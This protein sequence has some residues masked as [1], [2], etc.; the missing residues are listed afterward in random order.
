MQKLK[1]E[2]LESSIVVLLI[3]IIITISIATTIFK[4]LILKINFIIKKFEKKFFS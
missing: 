3:L 4:I 2:G 1:E